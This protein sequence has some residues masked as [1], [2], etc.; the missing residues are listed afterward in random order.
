[1]I[2]WAVVSLLLYIAGFGMAYTLIP[3][4]FPISMAGQKNWKRWI[5]AALWPA[6][7][8]AFFGACLATMF[9]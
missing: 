6:F 8:L 5:F 4:N 3:G 9:A 2:D 1:M 7:G